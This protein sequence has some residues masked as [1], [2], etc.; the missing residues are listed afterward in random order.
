MF[1]A[2][3]ARKLLSTCAAAGTGAG[4]AEEGADRL[5][6]PAAD[7]PGGH[8]KSASSRSSQSSVMMLDI[9][10]ALPQRSLFARWNSC[11]ICQKHDVASA[12]SWR[13]TR[14]L[15]VKRPS[16]VTVLD[17]LYSV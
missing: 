3:H 4:L 11:T 17:T 2:A 14:L 10:L 6:P 16:R 5:R 12:T 9:R 13:N 7:A 1:V 8:C 15:T